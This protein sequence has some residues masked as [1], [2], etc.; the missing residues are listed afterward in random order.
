MKKNNIKLGGLYFV[1]DPCQPQEVFFPVLKASLDAGIDIIQLWNNW[2]VQYRPSDK[3]KFIERVAEIS[4]PYEIPLLINEDW[5][6]LQQAPLHGVHFDKVPA[7]LDRIKKSIGRNF[8]AGLTCGNNSEAIQWAELHGM[9]YISFCAMFPSNSV[10]TCEIVRHETV[11]KAR[12]ITRMPIFLAGGINPSNIKRLSR[13][14][15]Q[16]V[17][18]ISGIMNSNDPSEAIS[19]YKK[20]LKEMG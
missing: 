16:G 4:S 11:L 13:L 3:L 17:A 6:L 1:M 14:D 20:I 9:D 15:F 2:P 10:D 19:A 12:E 8:L 18:V 7:S 5:Q